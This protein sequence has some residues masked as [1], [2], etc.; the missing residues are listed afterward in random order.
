MPKREVIEMED[1]LLKT[2]VIRNTDGEYVIK[3]IVSGGSINEWSLGHDEAIAKGKVSTIL[4]SYMNG[5]EF[6]Q[7]EVRKVFAQEEDKAKE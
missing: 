5:L 4:G 1:S 3:V 2:E 7:E 6:V